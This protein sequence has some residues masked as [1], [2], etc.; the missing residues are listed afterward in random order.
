[1]SCSEQKPQQPVYLL[2]IRTNLKKNLSAHGGVAKRLK[3]LT[4]CRG[5][6]VFSPF[7]ALP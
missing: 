7:R 5:C 3:M 6:S 2:N 4:Y 1:M